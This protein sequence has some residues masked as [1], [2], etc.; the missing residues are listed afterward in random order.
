M[1]VATDRREASRIETTR[2]VAFGGARRVFAVREAGVLL[3]LVVLCAG[4]SF[5]SPYFFTV[6]NIFNVLQ[7]MSTIGIM[8]VGMTMVLIAG[9]L[10]LSVGSVLAVG[11][12]LTARLMT[13]SGLNP[14]LSVAV[15]LGAGMAIGLVNGLLSTRAKIVPFIA[16]N[17]EKTKARESITTAA[18]PKLCKAAFV[19]TGKASLTFETPRDQNQDLEYRIEARVTDAS[20]REIIGNG[21]ARVTRHQAAVC[22]CQK[23]GC[24]PK[25]P[26]EV[27]RERRQNVFRD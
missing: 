21:T 7:G 17:A 20:R 2:T 3:A 10:D 26:V 6:R 13:Y 18:P 11:A 25:F 24:K 19:A 4:L 22:Q 23:A 5:A 1:V 14:W 12:V 9:G 8:A 15:G 27:N 16:P